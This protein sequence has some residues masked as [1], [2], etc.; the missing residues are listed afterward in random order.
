MITKYEDSQEFELQGVPCY[1]PPIGHIF[2]SAD[3][4]LEKIGVYRRSPSKSGQFWERNLRFNYDKERKQEKKDQRFD[5]DFVNYDL[6]SFRQDEWHRRMYGYWFWNNGVETYV[7]G[8]HYFFLTWWKLD[9]GYA[10]FRIPDMEFFYFLEHCIQNPASL[11]MLEATKRRQGKTVRAGCFLY[12]YASRKKEA[13][14]GIQSKSFADARDN[15]YTKGVLS[16]FKWLPDFFV[17]TYDMEKGRMPKSGLYFRQTNLK[18]ARSEEMDF[19]HELDSSLTFKAADH[20]SYDGFKLHRYVADEVGKC[21]KPIDVYKRH[22][23]VQFCMQLD[24]N[25]IG[26]GLYTTTVEEMNAGGEPFKR[27]W[28]A[29][30]QY[31]LNKNGKTKSGLSRYFLPAFKTLYFDKHG[32]PDEDR[33]KEYYMN[34]REGLRDDPSALASFIR[35]N[36]FTVEEMFFIDSE[37]C[38]FDSIRLNEQLEEVS[39]DPDEKLT[40]QGDLRW[41]SGQ[42]S[43]VIFIPSKRGRFLLNK[44]VLDLDRKELFNVVAKSDSGKLIP[45]FPR[46]IAGADP[47]DHDVTVDGRRS[48]GAGYVYHKEDMLEPKMANT[49]LCQYIFR[50]QKADLFYEDMIKMVHFFGC[51]ILIEDNKRGMINYFKQRGYGRFVMNFNDKDGISGSVKSH[52]QIAEE[53]EAYVTDHCERVVFTR[54]LTDWLLFDLNNTTKFDAAMASGY[55]L[56]ASNKLKYKE[57]AG[58]QVFLSENLVEVSDVFQF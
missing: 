41:E 14:T 27:L 7:T 46:R 22:Q 10:Q 38:L 34:E 18:G 54:L 3:G 43:T 19:S 16:P 33:A 4:Q 56:I 52:N 31:D 35:K 13:Q 15:V 24:G 2:N 51:E 57:K 1:T 12:D 44:Q 11:G 20:S 37:T 36:P 47:F 53:I 40:V 29:S 25:I 32:F 30:N 21:E 6:E 9:V 39:Y 58:K 8:L 48:D 28:E 42:D 50:P 17:P 49:F 55:T 26:K 5:E 23:I 45:Q